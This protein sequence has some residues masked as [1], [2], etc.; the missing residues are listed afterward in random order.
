MKRISFLMIALLM[1]GGMAMAQGPRR[2]GDT[3]MDPKTRAERMTERM[4]K[5]YSLND[6]QKKKLFE[7]NLAMAEQ[8]MGGC[9]E[10]AKS[11]M[12]QGKKDKNTQVTD[13]CCSNKKET[14]KVTKEDR[15]KMRNEMKA[16]REAYDTQLKKIL[17]KEQY[18]AYTTR[19]AE[20]QQK[21]K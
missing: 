19:Q 12:K 10:T 1:I 20:R 9:S 14:K 21:R 8:Q 2:G 7:I 3:K 11:D 18:D 6:T 16:S 4:V 13:N 5:E 17:T 15:E